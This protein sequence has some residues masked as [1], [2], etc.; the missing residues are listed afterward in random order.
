MAT[1]KIEYGFLTEERINGLREMGWSDEKIKNFAFFVQS[2]GG[3]RSED[4]TYKKAERMAYV[5][6]NHKFFKGLNEEQKI[7]KINQY[8]LLN[9]PE[10]TGNTFYGERMGN[11]GGTDGYAFRGRGYVQLT[12]R[13]NY[14]AIGKRL[15]VDL[16]TDP[17]I[18]ERDDDLAWR[19]SVEFINM[20]DKNNRAVT[21]DGMHSV[22]RPA[23]TVQDSLKRV[24]LITTKEMGEL[25]KRNS[26]A[27]AVQKFDSQSKPVEAP[28]MA[29]PKIQDKL[30]ERIVINTPITGKIPKPKM[31]KSTTD[32]DFNEGRISAETWR[33]R[34]WVELNEQEDLPP[35]DF[36]VEFPK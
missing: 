29:P 4:L 24:R 16:L 14:D 27:L 20:N 8:G 6:R 5:F 34:K 35:P 17:S 12:G 15:K 2:E 33:E 9:N 13:S 1:K 25:A 36:I 19:A 18:L 26:Q 23:T 31:P 22:I 32:V 7:E 30:E 21:L 11:K 28:K 3:P 10:L